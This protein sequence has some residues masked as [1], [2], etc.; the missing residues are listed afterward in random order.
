MFRP[1]LVLTALLAAPVLAQTQDE[2]LAATL[3]PGWRLEGGNRMAALQLTL[4]PQWKTYWRA[5]GEGG[6]PPV[7][8]WTGSQNLQGVTLLWPSP[9]VFVQNGMQSIGYSDSLVLPLEIT[10]ID[11][12]KP[13]ELRL[14][15]TLGVCKDICL[16]ASLTLTASLSGAGSADGSIDLALSQ[17][18]L[19]PEAAGVSKVSCKVDPISDG[20]RVQA[21]LVMPQQGRPETV[22]FEMADP[23]VWVAE[24]DE[25][26]SGPVLTSAADFV[27][28]SAAP[29]VLNRTDV[30]ITVIG[31]DRSVEIKGCPAP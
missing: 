21:S 1:L 25:S 9:K 18:P 4:A 6:I 13:V 29:F 30:T 11:P 12:D 8:D 23:T 15:M 3:L 5:P 20:L 31:Q 14:Q 10:P 28:A 22:V 16:P 7:L 19:D 27:P 2:M 26:R 17:R 24:A